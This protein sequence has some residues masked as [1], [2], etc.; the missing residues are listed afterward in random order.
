MSTGPVMKS[1][2]EI[3]NR[4]G[5]PVCGVAV[6]KFCIASWGKPCSLL[7]GDRRVAG[8]AG[9]GYSYRGGP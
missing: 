7:H 2:D 9:P 4:V 1:D 3:R 8:G 5:C 6:G